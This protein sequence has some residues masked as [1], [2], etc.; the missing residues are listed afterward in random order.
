MPEFE[1]LN[2][3]HPACNHIVRFI[4]G[5]S[6]KTND[7]VSGIILQVRKYNGKHT[8]LAVDKDVYDIEFKLCE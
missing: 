5:Y 4:K 2:V 6:N 3:Y 7:C 8:D 1:R